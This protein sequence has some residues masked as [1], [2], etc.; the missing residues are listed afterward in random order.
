MRPQLAELESL[1]TLR[2][3]RTTLR[4]LRLDDAGELH[5]VF[6][7]PETMRYWSSLPHADEQRTREMI[8]SIEAAFVARSV[9][10]WG[11]ERDRDGRVLGTVTLMPEPDQP[12]A[13]LGYIIGRE[14]WGKGYAGEAQ[15]RAVRFAFEEL[16]LQRLEAD[17]HPGNEA[18]SRS[19][20][21]LGFRQEGR[22]RERWLVGSKFSDSIVWGLLAAEWRAAQPGAD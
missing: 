21:R 6:S 14:H 10:Q 5:A 12:R 22:L 15:R 3:A 8:T 4:A 17:T 9:L 1:P 18:S 20:E 16:G 11:I 7:D 13:E 19:L 2:T